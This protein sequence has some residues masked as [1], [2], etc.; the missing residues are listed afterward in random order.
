MP[1]Y[2][3]LL[4]ANGPGSWIWWD[5]VGRHGDTLYAA[6]REHVIL[7]F[8]AVAIGMAIALPL[9]VAAWRWRFVQAPALGLT[10]AIYTVPSLALF[11]MLV[12][13]TGLGRTTAE[14][15]LVGYTLLILIRNV[16]AGLDGV[17]ADVREA[18]R[19]MGLTPLRT[20]LR[21][22]LPL[23]VPAIVAGVRIATVTTIGL[24]TVT[25]LIGQG[26]FGQLIYDGLLRDFRTPLV[27]G[28]VLS[29][30]LAAGADV[31]LVL[32]ERMLTPWARS[33]GRVV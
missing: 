30:A 2:G 28:T 10:G 3:P 13:V 21:V 20:L 19:G 5:W 29:V 14:I 32:A 18:A 24:V 31:L 4:G 23:A 9:G 6:G 7:T 26:G 25:A 11:A 17:P 15:G 1:S 12:P 16:V 8:W 22:E 27:L 33:R